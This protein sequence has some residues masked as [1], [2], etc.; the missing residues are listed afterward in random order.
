MD[1]ERIERLVVAVVERLARKLGADGGRERIVSVFSGCTADVENAAAQV[2]RLVM[3]GF[4]L[5]LLFSD[6][7]ED[8]YRET[9]LGML[10]GFPNIG[11]V[12]PAGWYRELTRADAVIAPVA[13]LNTV[14]RLSMLMA[15]TPH[16]QLLLGAMTMG[17]PLIIARDGAFPA[18]MPLSGGMGENLRAALAERLALIG[19]FGAVLCDMN[20]L[21]A[22]LESRFKEEIREE[23]EKRLPR[24]IPSIPS[25]PTGNP[26]GM[27]PGRPRRHLGGRV[28]SAS[29]VN[30][31]ARGG[32][33][34]T[35]GAGGIVTP[36]AR[37]LASRNGVALEEV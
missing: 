22:T 24:Q 31:A 4:N 6:A 17:K 27:G 30:L 29:H 32:Y 3:K 20:A 8:S 10:E 1:D 16:T 9:A 13:S 28:L 36:M 26:G 12:E 34:L 15:D 21:G 2:R 19:G 37:D 18:G 14:T 11:T 35:Y 33:D 25:G 23:H 5:N 7:A